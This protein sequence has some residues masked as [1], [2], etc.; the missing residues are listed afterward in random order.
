MALRDSGEA[1]EVLARQVGL[2]RPE[3]LN[4]DMLDEQA[5]QILGLAHPNDI[6][7]YTR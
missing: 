6:V 5:R 4:R 2:L 1:R 7:I 3:N